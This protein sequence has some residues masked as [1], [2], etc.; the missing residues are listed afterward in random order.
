V[1]WVVRSGEEEGGKKE[2]EE[3]KRGEEAREEGKVKRR[4][5]STLNSIACQAARGGREHSVPIAKH[6]CAA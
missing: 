1:W 3:K 4:S 6:I 5:G 2:E